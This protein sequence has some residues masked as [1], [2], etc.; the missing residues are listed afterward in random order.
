[1]SSSPPFQFW[2]TLDDPAAWLTADRDNPG[3][4]LAALEALDDPEIRSVVEVGPG[5]GYD[6]Q[7][8]WRGSR[9]QYEAIEGSPGMVAHLKRTLPDMPVRV[10]TFEDLGTAAYDLAYVKAVLEH[11]R[12]F[13][14][15]LGHLLRAARRKVLV[16][17]YLPPGDV[18]ELRV[19]AHGIPANRYARADVLAFLAEHGAAAEVQGFMFLGRHQE[20]WTIRPRG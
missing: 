2:D 12:G 9:V 14:E 15:A 4:A 13:R 8:F 6:W 10:G 18:E 5:P 17:W 1:M 20:L 16:E 3:R 7:D 19:D 11:Q